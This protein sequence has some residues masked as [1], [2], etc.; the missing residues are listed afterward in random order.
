MADSYED[1]ERALGAKFAKLPQSF[2][3]NSIKNFHLTEFRSRYGH[4]EAIARAVKTLG[5][6]EKVSVD[7][8]FVSAIN[9]TKTKAQFRE[10]TYRLMLADMLAL[11]ETVLPSKSVIDHLDV[12][13]ATR[14]IKGVRQTSV[15]DIDHDVIESLP[16]AMEIDLATRGLIDL[17]GKNLKVRMEYATDSWGLICADFI[18]NI[19]YHRDKPEE[20]DVLAGLEAAGRV[21]YFESFG[22]FEARRARVAERNGDCAAA[23][24]EWI[25]IAKQGGAVDEIGE[26]IQRILGKMVHRSGSSGVDVVFESLLER[27][28]RQGGASQD[29]SQVLAELQLLEYEFEKFLS[30]NTRINYDHLQFRLRNL[31]LIA[32][33]HLGLTT[34]GTEIIALQSR[35]ATS[36]A[37]NPE[38]FNRV[39]DYRITATETLVNKLEIEDALLHALEYSKIVENYY[40]V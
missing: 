34:Y 26:A 6:L 13:V 10:R 22:G 4:E 19:N 23:L 32:C 24:H 25:A 27:I 3:E 33:N 9:F 29:F 36:L 7:Y 14:T 40:E 17:L 37:T 8:N 20:R 38:Y 21:A 2:G 12:V 18:A 28:W 11:L 1:S 30:S 15:S 16:F 5:T 35:K 39:L 31:M